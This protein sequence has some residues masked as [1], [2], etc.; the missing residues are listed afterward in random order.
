MS[1][2]AE[3]VSGLLGLNDKA[4]PELKIEDL[5]SEVEFWEKTAARLQCRAFDAQTN[6]QLLKDAVRVAEVT[7]IVK[8]PVL[9]G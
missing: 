1:Q 3:V 7:G 5:K 9:V 8:H 2:F 6:V 4:H